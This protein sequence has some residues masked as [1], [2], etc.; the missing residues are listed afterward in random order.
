MVPGRHPE[1]FG[2]A[3]PPCITDAWAEDGEAQV[4]AQAELLPVL[5]SKLVWARELADAPLIVF[6]DNDGARHNLVGGSSSSEASSRLVGASAMS[7]AVLSCHQWVARVPTGANVADG[8]SRLDFGT[9]VGM[10]AVRVHV[11]PFGDVPDWPG[12]Q[13]LLQ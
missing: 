13:R 3:V 5:L 12:V 6:I 9:V 2:V 11:P 10:G 7:D 1:F 8:P 4:I